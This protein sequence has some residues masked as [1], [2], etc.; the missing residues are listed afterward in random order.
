MR[1]SPLRSSAERPGR[2]EA[3]CHPGVD[4]VFPVGSGNFEGLLD[5]LFSKLRIFAEEFLTVRIKRHGFP[6]TA[7]PEAH[8]PDARLPVP[9]LRVCGDPVIACGG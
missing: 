2:A 8:A 3:S 1:A 9:L 7:K 6:D 4:H 5:V